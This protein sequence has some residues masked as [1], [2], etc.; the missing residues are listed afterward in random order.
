L[1]GLLA[2]QLEVLF[3]ANTDDV[4]KAEKDVKSTGSRIEK[5]KTTA[6]IDANSKPALEGMER[7]EQ[8]AKKLVS[9][10]TIAMIDANISKA[11]TATDAVRDRLDYLRSVETDLEVKAD[12][13]RAEAN[14]QRMER[15]LDALRSARTKVEVD[16]DVSDAERELAGLADTV[17]GSGEDAGAQFSGSV[18]AALAAIPIA[19]S[20]VAIG[21]AIGQ[22]LSQGVQDGLQQEVGRDRLQAL[23]GISEADAAKLG[24]TA[25]E[26]YANGF[27]ESIEQNMD[28]TRLGVQFDLIDP[29][30]TVRDSQ[31]VIE[32]ISGIADVL[33]EEVQPVARATAILLRTG[34]ASSAQDAFDVI[35]T[36]ARE[37]VNI[38]DDL[39]DTLSEYG[40]TFASLGLTG[41]ES[42]GLLN[43]ALEAGVPNTDFFADALR[44]L[45]IFLRDGSD[46]TAGFVEQLGLVPSEMQAAFTEGGPA[47]AEGLDQIFD[48]LRA[49]EDPIERNKIAV[50]LLGTQFEDL[51]LDVSKLDLSTAEAQLNGV[52]GS[53]QRM[54]DTL[55]SNDASSIEGA[56]RNIEVA[57]DGIKGA[58]AAGFAE[59]LADAA[60]FVSENR[61][62]MIG[63]FSDLVDGALE[64][65]HTLIDVAADGSEAF[66][67]FV[68]GPLAEIVEGVADAI[69]VLNGFGGRP[70][71]LDD[72]A[73][74]MRGFKDESVD[75]A[76]NIRGL[77]DGLD[78]VSENV[79]G[80]LDGAEAMGYLN[81][82]SLRLATALD[83][84]GYSAE[85]GA[86]LIGGYTVA[87]DG[88]VQA[89]AELESQIR[90]SIAAMSDEISAAAATGEAQD[91][92]T[93]RYNTAT[94][95][96]VGQLTQMGLTETQARALIDTVM[97]TPESKATAFSSNAPEQQGKVQSLNDRIVTLEDGSVVVLADTKPAQNSIDAYVAANTGRTITVTTVQRLVQSQAGS[98]SSTG[99]PAYAEQAQGSVLEFYA[100]GGLRGLTPM[101]PIAQMVPASTWR[102]VGDR[103]DVPEAY[104]PL[105]GS[106]RSMAILAET[107]QRMGVQ[108]MADGGVTTAV[109]PQP[110]ARDRPITM[111]GRLFGFLREQ[112]NGDARIIVADALSRRTQDANRGTWQ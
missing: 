99:L 8:A 86:A 93:G 55:A 30:A 5:Q 34:L 111:D 49:V 20:V 10:K 79:H 109:S 50:G 9:A 98:Y 43:Q 87:Q 64:F 59:P 107:M 83:T 81:D 2:A 103:S 12:V 67:E 89:G 48:R 94:G 106:A 57:A 41:A 71:E 102:V 26:A 52:Q 65:G 76:E 45:G 91:V 80:V 108:Q 72:L 24:R 1:A 47:A 39:L 46:E 42:V 53:A 112:A 62:P 95:A 15:Q 90:N 14:L 17:G 104:I 6:K 61:G 28:I 23:T 68:S 66:G 60:E 78:R 36:G 37:G 44:E 27:G 69:D 101:R 88:S 21:A 82:A 54:F 84:V 33:G 110:V 35:A 56:M 7:V 16:A 100:A 4:A 51:Q 97:Q 40:S 58:L 25:S 74:G 13:A 92:L 22:A 11:E 19:G 73:A 70:K 85:T 32:G 29:A 3:T 105:D 18:I 77:H 96:L 63:F 38:S 31:K 75:A